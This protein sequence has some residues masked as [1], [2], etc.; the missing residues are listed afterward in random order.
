MMLAIRAD[1]GR[2]DH[3]CWRKATVGWLFLT[4]VVYEIQNVI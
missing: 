3:C 4:L 2:C 1:V